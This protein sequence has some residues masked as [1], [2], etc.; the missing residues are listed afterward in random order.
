MALVSPAGTEVALHERKGG[1]DDNIVATYTQ[2]TTPAL[3][4][5]AGQAMAGTWRLRVSDHEAQDVG[6]LRRWKVTLRA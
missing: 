3:A 6:K 4:A 5:L 1:Q 2:A